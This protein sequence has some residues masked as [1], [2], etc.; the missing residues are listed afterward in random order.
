MRG[1]WCFLA[2]FSLRV[3]LFLIW[4]WVAAGVLIDGHVVIALTAVLMLWADAPR[5]YRVLQQLSRAEDL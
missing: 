2:A 1:G 4:A 3:A 5:V